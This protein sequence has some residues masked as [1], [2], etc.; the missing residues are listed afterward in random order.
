MIL[1]F[2]FI[3]FLSSIQPKEIKS[4]QNDSMKIFICQVSNEN[5]NSIA[6]D[7]QYTPPMQIQKESYFFSNE[8]IEDQYYWNKTYYADIAEIENNMLKQERNSLTESE[9]ATL[10]TILNANLPISA[11]A[12]YLLLQQYPEM[13]DERLIV[14]VEE[15][16]ETALD[17]TLLFDYQLTLTPNPASGLVEASFVVPN[18][19]TQYTLRV[20]DSYQNIGQ[21]KYEV[22]K[23][24]IVNAQFDT[25][26]WGVGTYTVAL[27][28]NE[29]VV[30]TTHLLVLR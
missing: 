26:T 2:A 25:S 10:T 23:N 24:E 20:L 1:L 6:I 21:L 8:I 30:E 15:E 3:N 17:S 9:V 7:D 5:Q 27:I 12:E 18:G 11:H 28:I 4:S 19:V 22:N 13:W 14:K 29:E 16:Y